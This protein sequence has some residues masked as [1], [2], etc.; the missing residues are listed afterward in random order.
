MRSNFFPHEFGHYYVHLLF[1]K[2]FDIRVFS[3]RSEMLILVF[4]ADNELLVHQFI[5]IDLL[6]DQ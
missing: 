5:F 1:S 2:G 3:Y 6:G 4:G